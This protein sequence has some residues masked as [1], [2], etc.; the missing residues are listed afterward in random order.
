[1][2]IKWI[3]FALIGYECMCIRNLKR[4]FSRMQWIL[5]FRTGDSSLLNFQ[6]T[7]EHIFK[8]PFSS[9]P[10]ETLPASPPQIPSRGNI[11]TSLGQISMVS[12]PSMDFLKTTWQNLN[13]SSIIQYEPCATYMPTCP[14][15]DIC[16][17]SLQLCG[18]HNNKVVGRNC[19]W[20]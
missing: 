1:M 19:L 18:L 12:G 20:R 5:W 17:V 2:P 9:D 16:W 15:G 3:L 10:N 14:S 7:R 11:C 6:H 8:W 13:K 4:H